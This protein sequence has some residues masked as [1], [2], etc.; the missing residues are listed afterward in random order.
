VIGLAGRPQWRGAF[1]AAIGFYSLTSLAD[2]QTTVL[3]LLI[4]LLIGSSAGSGLALRGRHRLGAPV[5]A[6]DR[7]RACRPPISG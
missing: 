1:W 6:E 5:G 4:T 2:A 7:H 3:A